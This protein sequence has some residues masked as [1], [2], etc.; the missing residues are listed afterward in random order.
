MV[1]N[2]STNNLGKKHICSNCGAKF[3][4]LGKSPAKCPKCGTIAKV[5]E[6]FYPAIEPKPKAAKKDKIHQNELDA[7]TL[8]ADMDSIGAMDDV[9]DEINSLSE[10]DDRPAQGQHAA[11]DDDV[12]EAELMEEMKNYDVILDS[13]EE[14]T[15]AEDKD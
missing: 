15:Q 14:I 13:A 1:D 4:D 5:E 9:D 12:V 10:L 11:H 8:T 3:Y 2:L 6:I 7:I